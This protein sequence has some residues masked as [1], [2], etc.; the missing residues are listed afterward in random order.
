M[1]TDY[2]NK[3]FAVT[4]NPEY[5]GKKRHHIFV[6]ESGNSVL[7]Y[8]SISNY[9]KGVDLF[10]N[11]NLPC[12]DEEIF[13]VNYIQTRQEAQRRH[14]A[15]ALL[16]Y[17]LNEVFYK[18]NAYAVS[19]EAICEESEMLLNKV[20][21]HMNLEVYKRKYETSQEYKKYGSLKGHIITR[22]EEPHKYFDFLEDKEY[23]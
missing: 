11:H 2:L 1:D 15:T 8:I 21:G 19:Y 10:F 6:A 9:I 4:H 14:L 7:G 23:F 22:K 3:S 20:S 5:K 12:K 18:D 17:A 13:Y 16:G